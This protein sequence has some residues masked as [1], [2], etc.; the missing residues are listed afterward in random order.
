VLLAEEGDFKTA[1][2]YFF[3]AFET[4]HGLATGVGG[5][6]DDDVVPPR[7]YVCFFI[8]IFYFIVSVFK[9]L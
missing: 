9:G 7:E 4:G 6:G 5:G 8:Y 1:Y 2:S 3:E